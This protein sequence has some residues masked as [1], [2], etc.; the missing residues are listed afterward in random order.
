MLLTKALLLLA[1]A[2]T[3]VHS[4]ACFFSSDISCDT[5]NPGSSYRISCNGENSIIGLFTV[6]EYLIKRGKILTT[7][8]IK[9]GTVH[10][11]TSSGPLNNLGKDFVFNCPAGKAITD[12]RYTYDA[13]QDDGNFQFECCAIQGKIPTNCKSWN[14]GSRMIQMS[15]MANFKLPDALKPAITGINSTLV[16][17]E[18]IKELGSDYKTRVYDILMCSIP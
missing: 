10:D 7:M 9:V 1:C 16:K 4:L 14:E 18:L 11:C 8:C 15:R 5:R 13:K 3:T 2:A 12:I 17:R 6:E